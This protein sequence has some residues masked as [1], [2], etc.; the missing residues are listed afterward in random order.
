MNSVDLETRNRIFDE[1]IAERRTHRS[2]TDEPVSDETILS[3]ISAGLHA[4]YASAAAKGADDIRK[5]IVIRKES[6][7]MTVIK[8][9]LFREVQE[10][11]KELEKA[12][13]SNEEFAEKAGS[14]I[15]RISMI[16]KMGT[17]PGIGTAPVYLVVA[18]KK[19]FPPVQQASL[20]HCLENMWLK[21]T[22]LGLG[23]QL[24]SI[25]SQM[26]TL[27][28]FCEFLDIWPGVWELNGCAIGYPAEKLPESVRPDARDV[29]TWIP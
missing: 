16:K 3:I 14:F 19:G 15:K 25:T 27:D 8:P 12:A 4:P 13:A 7:I 2:F 1:I 5:F 17:V 10:M 23:F 9:M 22:A 28:D 29:T 24:V 21:A 18:E 26:E 11:S 6:E 20:A